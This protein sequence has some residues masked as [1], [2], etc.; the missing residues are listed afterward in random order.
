M[1]PFFTPISSI[2]QVTDIGGLKP[3]P[4]L[5]L[6]RRFLRLLIHFVRLLTGHSFFFWFSPSPP[7]LQVT[8]HKVLP[9][10]SCPSVLRQLSQAPLEFKLVTYIS[11][12]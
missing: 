3:L 8:S 11:R 12:K 7:D 2:R 9:S 10:T 1:D 6:L 5:V 4:L